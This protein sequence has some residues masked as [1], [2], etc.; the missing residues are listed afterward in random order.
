MSNKSSIEWTDA[1]WNPITG[2]SPCSVGCDNCYAERLAGRLRAMGNPRY[3][4]G[5]NVVC[6]YDLI[7]LPL[8][9]KKPRMIFVNSMSDI[10]H[11]DVPDDFI[12]Q[13]FATMRKAHRHTFQVLTKR[14][15]RLKSIQDKLIW[16]PNI[17]FGVTIESQDFVSRIAW[18]KKSNAITKFIS[19]E[20]LLSEIQGIDIKG[21]DWIIVGGESGPKSRPIKIEWVRYLRDLAI[22]NRIPFF[23]KQWGGVNKK[24]SGKLLDG[25][26]WLEYPTKV[27]NL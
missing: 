15:E 17:W 7:E 12:V 20:P 27:Q 25:F 13:L 18:L 26:E 9:W 10:F 1:T 8:K 2:C 22:K 16:A 4:E 23:F 6:H 21:I 3:K 5:F 11:E 24:K 19:F 14:P